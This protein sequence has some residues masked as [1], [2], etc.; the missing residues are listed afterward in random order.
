MNT[1][2]DTLYTLVRK[3]EVRQ[4][5][6]SQKSSSGSTDFH[7]DKYRRYPMAAGRMA[8]LEEEELFPPDPKSHESEIPEFDPIE[9]L[10]CA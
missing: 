6:H 5:Q 8:T 3:L 1:S 2:F 9:G 10:T 7:R 4:P